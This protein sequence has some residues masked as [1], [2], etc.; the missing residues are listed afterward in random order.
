MVNRLRDKGFAVTVVD[1]RGKDETK[2]KYML[3]LEIDG[4]T[5]N[6]LKQLIKTIDK[7]AF[8]IV[9]ETKYVQNGFFKSV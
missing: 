5:M 4:N 9:T 8:I 2:N 3:L 1:V 6:E 7:H